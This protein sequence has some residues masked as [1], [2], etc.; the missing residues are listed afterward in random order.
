MVKLFFW[1]NTLGSCSLRKL[2]F[3]WLVPV[4]EKSSLVSREI[5]FPEYSWFFI[6][7]IP[8]TKI[9]LIP[10]PL[11]LENP[12]WFNIAMKWLYAANLKGFEGH[13]GGQMVSVLGF[14]SDDPSFNPAEPYSF[15][16]KI[17]VWKEQKNK[18]EDGV[19]PFKKSKRF[20]KINPEIFILGRSR[21]NKTWK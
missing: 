10:S 21:L 7:I 5:Q 17:C 9:Y 13:G 6:W 20:S 19:G 14:Y 16:C 3:L 1:L 11:K 12:D 18:K 8:G 2:L 4:L 15:F